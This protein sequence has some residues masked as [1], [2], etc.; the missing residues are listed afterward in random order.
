MAHS[1]FPGMDPYLEAPGLWPDVH[2]SLIGIFREQL[3][4]LLAPKYVAEL[5]TQIVIDQIVDDPPDTAIAIPDVAVTQPSGSSSEAMV[6]IAPTT[7]APLRLAVPTAV[8][9]RH[10]SLYIRLRENEKLVA[11]IELLSPTNKRS[12]ENRQNYL[13]KRMS[14]FETRIHLVEIDLLRKWSR[15]PLEGTL[16]ESAYLAMVYNAYERFACDVWPINLRQPLP[17]LPV[18]LLKPDPP[19]SLD[20]GQALRTA[21]ERAR[22]DLRIDYAAPLSPPLSPVD[23][24]WAASLPVEATG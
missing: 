8:P 9:T 11:A 21:Y 1:P 13:K 22:Y 5:D 2:S 23:A 3:T 24:E 17:V 16:P 12:G 20:V 14:Y 10:I 6:A 7:S 18:P 19:V 4:P 15:M